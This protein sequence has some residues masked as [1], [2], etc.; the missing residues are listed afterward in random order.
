[1]QDVDAVNAGYARLLLDDYLDDP[2]SVPEE[3]RVLFESGEALRGLPGLDRLLERLPR[4]GVG[5]TNGHAAREA[6]A[7][8]QTDPELLGGVAAGMALVKAFRMHGHLAAALDP[9]GSAPIGD[10]ALDP[11]RLQPR[12]TPELQARVPASVLR[13]HVGGETLAGALPHLQETYCGSM[14]Y[15]IEHISEHFQRVWLR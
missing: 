12:L 14:A 4:N 6:P 11:L 3:W 2:G 1:M 7:A 9:L 10:P 13:I 15:E 5:A 8:S